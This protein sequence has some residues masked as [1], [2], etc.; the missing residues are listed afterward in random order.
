MSTLLQDVRYGIRMLAKSPGFT[1]VAVIT[2]ALGIGA[3]TAIFSVVNA[4]LVRPL[5]YKDA[6]RLVMLWSTKLREGWR[7]H[8]SPLDFVTW[9]KQCRSFK[10][11]AAIM[12][13]SRIL[14][15]RGEPVELSDGWISDGFFET[16]GVAPQ[17]GRTFAAAEHRAGAGRVVLIGNGLWRE[18]F[19][20]DPGVIGQSIRLSDEIFTVVGVMPDGLQFPIDGLKVWLPLELNES[21][22][23]DRHFFY[24]VGRLKDDKV[25]AEAQ[26]DVATIAGRLEK[27]FPKSHAGYGTA[28]VPL[29]ESFTGTLRPALAV[30]SGAVGMVLLIACGNVASL[31]LARASARRR[32]LALR[33]T[34]G[35]TRWRLTRILVVESLI[36]ACVGGVLGAVLAGWGVRLL[37]SS[38]PT[39]LPL[40]SCVKTISVD[41]RVLG[42]TLLL[43]VMTGILSGLLP[44]LRASSVDPNAA[45]KEGGGTTTAGLRQFRLRRALMVTELA[46]TMVLLVAA[47]LLMQ[48]AVRLQWTDPGLR[49]DHVLVMDVA[50]PAAKYRGPQQRAAFYQ[51]ALE[52]VRGLPGVRY[53]GVVNDLPLRNWTSFNF[54]V[55]GHPAPPPGE[56]PEALE[57][58]V[59]P[60]YFRAMAIPLHK[61]RTF[62]ND[63]G[64]N[65]IPVVMVNEALVQRYFPGE[66]PIGHRIRPGGPDDTGAP[67]Y[68]IVGV[69]GNVRHLGMDASAKPEIYNLHAQDPWPGMTL[70]VRTESDPV[71]LV[72]AVKQRIW[73]VDPYL[74]ISG[75]ARM[76]QVLSDSLWQSRILTYIQGVFAA[77]ALIMATVGLYGVVSQSVTLRRHE[78]GV[79]LALGA[80][81]SQILRLVLSQ[82]LTLILIGLGMGLLGS[83]ALSR[84]LTALLHDVRPTDP[85]TFAI[86]S[87]L[88]AVVALTACWLPA[89]RAAKVDPMESLR[90]E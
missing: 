49:P 4:V 27:E 30:L 83:I 5:P 52:R 71:A 84:S 37:L 66:D 76:T 12:P 74:P 70:V 26:A 40:P 73:T 88:L 10:S 41:N 19:G 38:L 61:G 31:L 54:T 20:S 78:F 48:N 42:F 9:R 35:A 89:R 87:L 46:L 50:L 24:V 14:T 82:G 63:E 72:P 81:P 7:G 69:V 53:A 1:A 25:V 34:L 79:R 23:D 29:R 59:S 60:D 22:P 45:L 11:M 68:T 8:A 28:V 15:G 3:N 39:D 62:T 80:A 86:V 17:M 58:V 6:D 85:W 32:E 33:L 90:Y 43:S 55:E 65:T 21:Q 2:L 13:G 56:V 57:R 36:L 16:L 44:A 67:W 47:G 51:E 18:R 77:I 64:P 75:V